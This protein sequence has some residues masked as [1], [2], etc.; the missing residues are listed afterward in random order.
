EVVDRVKNHVND[1]L[2]RYKVTSIVIGLGSHTC[3][4]LGGNSRAQKLSTGT[5][6]QL[7][8]CGEQ[9]RLRT[10]AAAL[11]PYQDNVHRVAPPRV[12]S[13]NPCAEAMSP[14]NCEGR[15]LRCRASEWD[16]ARREL[17]LAESSAR[18][19]EVVSPRPR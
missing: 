5:G 15:P 16:A 11:C 9:L 8:M 4:R 2:V 7:E 3:W 12:L 1:Q 17:R 13:P 14:P 6:L 10:F 18:S 19:P